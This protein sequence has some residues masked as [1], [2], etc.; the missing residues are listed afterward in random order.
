MFPG[1]KLGHKYHK[2]TV[3]SP[4]IFCAKIVG[5]PCSIVEPPTWVIW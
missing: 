4:F 1:Q 3:K 5:Q 2:Y